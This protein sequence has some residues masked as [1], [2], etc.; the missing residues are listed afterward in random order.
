MGESQQSHGAPMSTVSLNKVTP[1]EARGLTRAAQLFT[2][3]ALSPSTGV[4]ERSQP[5]DANRALESWQSETETYTMSQWLRAAS[6]VVVKH[7]VVYPSIFTTAGPAN[8]YIV[9][10]DFGVM[11]K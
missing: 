5:L 9:I 3:R 6:G 7:N 4:F 8:F 11:L 10:T 1:G 2:G